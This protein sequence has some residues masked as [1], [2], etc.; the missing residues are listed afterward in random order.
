MQINSLVIFKNRPARVINQLDKKVEILLEDEKT[1]KLPEKNLLLLHEGGF[2]DFNML[3]NG[4]E[5]ELQ[6]AWNLL[7]GQYTNYE[8]LSELIFSEYTPKS[9]YATWQQVQKGIYFTA[10]EREIYVNTQKQVDDIKQE[11]A[12]KQQKQ[13]K[14]DAFIARLQKHQYDAKEDEAFVKEIANFALGQTQNCRF[15][16]LINREETPQNAHALLLDIGF[17]DEYVNPYPIRVGAPVNPPAIDLPEIIDEVRQDFTHFESFAIDDED[18]H[19]PD[20]AISFDEQN[21]KLWVHVA[22]PAAI[23]DIDSELDIEARSRGS[24]LYL[25]EGVVPMLPSKVTDKLALGMESVSPALSIGF[26]VDDNG[27]I[28]DIEICL[29][30]IKVTRLSY[31]EAEE[32]LTQFPFTKFAQLAEAF[33]NARYKNGAIELQFP[34]IKLKLLEDKTVDITSLQTLKSRRLIR[35]AMLMAGVAVAKFADENNI[36]LPFSTQP[37]HDLTEDEQKPQTLSQMFAIRRKLQKGQYKVHAD[38]HAGMGLHHYVQVTSPLRRY[39]DLVVHQQLRAFLKGKTLLTSD[40]I[41]NRI[42][43]SEAGIKSARQ[44]ESLSNNHWKCVYLLQNPNWQGTA[45]VIE[46]SQNN[47]VTV[48]IPDLSLIKKL[49]LATSAQLDEMVH[50]ELSQVKL[51]SQDVYFKVV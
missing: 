37:P 48:F 23:V 33:S 18:S 47:R 24:N 8:E 45:Q 31:Q 40:E 41:L 28:N 3:D 4:F 27:Q 32:K 1:I 35:D 11:I 14:L 6:D 26:R 42:G 38:I 22:D 13:Q 15:F 49:T 36:P 43:Q 9:A 30:T 16:K 50:V 20:D 29:S 46:K 51:A 39:L 44:A 10:H 19:D 17:W 5:G 7:Q 12:E 34:E 25:P 21:N 2:T